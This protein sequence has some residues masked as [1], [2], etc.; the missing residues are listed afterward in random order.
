MPEIRILQPSDQDALED[1]LG[2]HL[3]SS[4]LLLSNS[5]RAGLVD[6]RQYFEGTYFAAFEDGRIVGVAAHYWIENLVLQSPPEHLE[7][8]LASATS[9]AIRPLRGLLGPGE[10]IARAKEILRL[11]DD[12]IQI[13]DREGLYSVKLDELI[14]PEA[15]ATGQLRGR[16]IE[17][18]DLEREAAWR[19]AYC[20][21]A[22]KAEDTPELRERCRNEME[23]SCERG[24][25]W[26]LE[27]GGEP[28]ASTSFNARLDEAVQVG[29]VW[30]PP[31][32]RS[33]GYARAAV[34]ASLLDARAEAVE[35]AILFTGDDNTA[36]IKAYLALGFRLIGDYRIILLREPWSAA[37]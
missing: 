1:F 25:T 28:V 21:E 26:V 22:I 27:H 36:A 11:T 37:P 14:V 29:G 23:G 33:R 35:R 32:L 30:T 5:R 18:R 2:P 6:R 15:L 20:L 10:Q 4:M 3:E 19:L 24:D 16:R 7:A 8:L 9:A 34:A 17:R 12:E 13:D 31:E